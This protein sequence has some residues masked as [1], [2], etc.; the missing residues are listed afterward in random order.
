TTE[1]Y[2]AEHKATMDQY[3]IKTSYLTCFSGAESV[4]EPSLYWFDELGEFRLNLIEPE[5]RQG[6][7]AIKASPQTREVALKLRE[8]LREL[9]FQLGACHLQLGKYYPFQQSIGNE[10]TRSILK[11]VKQVVDPKGL[12]NP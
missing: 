5:Y 10:A 12:M 8:G 6:W 11:G 9:F 2:F 3:N 7:G 1:R 4:L